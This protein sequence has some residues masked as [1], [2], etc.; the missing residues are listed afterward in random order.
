M[1][2]TMNISAQNAPVVTLGTIN[3]TAS[4]VNVPI[5]AVNF[6][7][8]S[9]CDLKILYNPAVATPVTLTMGTGMDIGGTLNV[10]MSI[11]GEIRLG[12]FAYPSVTL[13][14]GSTIFNV[15]FD[16]VSFGSSNL[17]FDDDNSGYGCSF[18]NS[19][20]QNLNDIPASTF[21]IPGSIS[22]NPVPNGPIT[23][24]TAVTA[25]VGATINVPVTVTGFN[26]IGAVSLMLNYDPTVISFNS[27]TNTGGFPGLTITNPLSGTIIVG[28]NNTNPAGYSLGNGSVLF[29]MNFTYL[30][31]TTALRW[32]DNG[33]SCEYADPLSVNVLNDIPQASYYIDGSVSKAVVVTPTISVGT[34]INATTCGSNGSIPLTFTNVPNGTYT[35][36]YTG[37]SFANVA[38]SGNNA[39]ILAPVGTYNNLQITVNSLSS[40]T[41]VNASLT[42]PTAPLAPTANLI[43]PACLVATG[44]ISVTSPMTGLFFSIDGVNYTNTT[45]IFTSVVSGTY[46]LTAM[47]AAGCVSPQA[48]FT[49]NENQTT[50]GQWLGVTSDWGK[51]FNWCGGIPTSSTNVTIPS[52][53]TQPV[54]GVAVSASC[55]NINIGNGA[56]LTLESDVNG[57]GSLIVSGVASGAGTLIA[58]RYLTT[59]AWHMVS[60]PLLGQSVAAFLSANSNIPT[61]GSSQRGMMD[62]DPTNNGWNSFFT[63]GAANGSLGGGK[64]FSMRVGIS[65]AAVIFT[66]LLQVGAMSALADANLWNCVG[67]PYTSAIGI[68]ANGSGTNTENFLTKNG[69]TN[70]NI[71]PNYGIYVWDQSDGSNNIYG[72]F[73]AISNVPNPYTPTLNLQQ[74]QAFFVKM[75]A[76]KSSVNFTAAMQLHSTGLPLKSTKDIWPTIKLETTADNQKSSTIIAFN[77]GMT[78]GLD[79]TYD[80]GLLKGSSDLI[81]YSKLVEDNGIPFAIQALPANDYNSMIIP[82]GLDFKTG[83]QVVFSAELTSMPSDAKVILEDKLL[84]TFTDLSKNDYTVTIAANSSIS[85]RFQIHTSYLTTGTTTDLAFEKLN[86]YAYRNIEIRLKGTV[87]AGATATLYDVQGRNILVKILEGSNLNIIPTPNIRTGIYMLSVNDH[88]KVT[89]FKIPVAE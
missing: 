76:A 22:F 65:N 86:A 8:I 33:G 64:G 80:A 67:N 1:G 70:T 32:F 60:S 72:R 53:V 6:T 50:P 61:N 35:I 81:V 11:P 71:D 26:N 75:N 56:T 83:G 88:G 3:T 25:N 59:G 51:D 69:V 9:S 18:Y 85:D 47:N 15:T 49:I 5:K 16:K 42:A 41:G 30:G 74:G 79:P 24:A 36:N 38:V 28:G 44:T 73:T 78:K 48:S 34:V 55:N 62:Y 63:D 66:G 4:A 45:G 31:G 40:V 21:Y 27:A 68:T 58:Q 87:S 39:T 14:S 7:N 37:G 13:N 52:G 82:V 54:I 20:L 57:T 10:N 17:I 89:G 77:N 12:W 46:S 84:K 23:T 2:I 29:T 19:S 43:Q